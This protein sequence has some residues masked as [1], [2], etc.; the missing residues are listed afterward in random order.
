MKMT[1]NFAGALAAMSLIGFVGGALAQSAGQGSATVL[2]VS[3]DARYSTGDN[4]WHTL[5]EGDI[6]QPGT[7]LQTASKSSVDI[8]LYNEFVSLGQQA[9][10]GAPTSLNFHPGGEATVNVVRLYENTV[11][12]VDKLSSMQTGADKVTETQLDLRA[13]KI[14]GSVKKMFGASKYEIK[15]PNGVA[16]VRGTVYF[17]EASGNVSVYSGSVVEAFTGPNGTTSTETVG[18]GFKFDPTTGQLT[19]ITG[20]GSPE[21]QAMIVAIK[22]LGVLPPGA[23]PS[24]FAPDVTTKWVSPT[25]GK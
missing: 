19:N 13:G 15:Y 14:F 25:I 11:L 2:R 1:R 10:G 21:Y 5:R 20:G 17:M 9:L 8:V 23:P 24:S 16:G 7:V 18:Q 3:G 4:Q 12:G 22:Q 6:V